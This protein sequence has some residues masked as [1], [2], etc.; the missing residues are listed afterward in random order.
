[1]PGIFLSSCFRPTN[2]SASV[3]TWTD[4]GTT[5]VLFVSGKRPATKSEETMIPITYH[6]LRSYVWR[7]YFRTREVLVELAKP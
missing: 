6:P 7:G 5:V 2:G 1:M 4:T 3:T